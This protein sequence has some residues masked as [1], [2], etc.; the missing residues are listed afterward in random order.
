MELV[1][2]GNPEKRCH[3]FLL[4]I[5]HQILFK[6]EDNEGMHEILNEVELLPLG[7]MYM[8]PMGHRVNCT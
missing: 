2:L 8:V 6:L 5:N 1:A 3:H 7:T 4:V